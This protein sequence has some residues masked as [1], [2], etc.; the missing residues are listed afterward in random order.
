[1]VNYTF[2]KELDDLAGVRDP[3]KD[4]LEKGPGAIDHP[5]VASATLVYQL[6]FGAATI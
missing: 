6:P 5:H 3:N 4:F 2:S 1:M